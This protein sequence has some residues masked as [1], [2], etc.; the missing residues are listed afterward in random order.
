MAT[1]TI[2][3]S[4]KQ[5]G[6]GNRKQELFID[7]VMMSDSFL[8][9]MT[10][11]DGVKSKAQIPVYDASISFGNDIC[12]VTKGGDGTWMLEEK[13]ITNDAFTW[14]FSN[15]KTSLQETYRSL[16]LRKGQLNEQTFDDDFKEWLFDYFAKRIGEKC[17]EVA[18]E[19][20]H[21]KVLS[22]GVNKANKKG[23]QIIDT[24]ATYA[25]VDE[26]NILDV[27]EMMYKGFSSD[28]I[29]SYM[30]QTDEEYK[31]VI[32]MN[33]RMIQH[34]QIAMSKKYTTTPVGIIEGQ[35]PG[36]MGFKVECWSYLADGE[37]IITYPANFLLITD[38]FGD[39]KALQSEYE[40][41]K[42]LDQFYGQFR[43]GFD[44]RREDLVV[45]NF[46]N[47]KETKTASTK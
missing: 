28:M 38:D 6:W 17:M 19:E 10:L 30:G 41:L 1:G 22:G 5:T 35:I 8:N 43:L 12:D 21:K 18:Y 23:Y 25:T 15:C 34:Y 27:L 31:P 24:A 14:Y 36:W 40:P 29:N 2:A 46:K 4:I 42:N 45:H 47:A 20:I 3:D 11:I 33:A 9:K 16:M 37:I 13:E 32:Y 26:T 7:K 44:I 39:V